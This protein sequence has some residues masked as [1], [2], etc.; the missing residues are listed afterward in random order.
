MHS[1][2][3]AMPAGLAAECQNRG[4]FLCAKTAVNL[5]VQLVL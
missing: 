3:L 2:F 4:V 1:R 5:Q